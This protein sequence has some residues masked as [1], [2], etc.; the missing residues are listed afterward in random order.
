MIFCE[1]VNNKLKVFKI[2]YVLPILSEETPLLCLLD[3][4]L[5]RPN[6]GI[7]IIIYIT[8]VSKDKNK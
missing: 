6:I 4:A 7:Y 1:V 8:L 2:I 3:W 5:L